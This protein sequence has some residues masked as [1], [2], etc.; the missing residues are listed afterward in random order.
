MVLDVLG[1]I[2]R[3]GILHLNLILPDG[4]RSLIPVAWTDLQ[5]QADDEPE[6][7]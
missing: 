3:N 7:V 4:T 2:H 5:G 6:T 1:H